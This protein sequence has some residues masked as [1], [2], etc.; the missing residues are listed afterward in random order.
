MRFHTEFSRY[1]R[2][3]EQHRLGLAY[4]R[5]LKSSLERKTAEGMALLLLNPVSV[6]RLQ[7]FITNYRWDHDGMLG[8]YQ[9]AL[10]R[11]IAGPEDEGMLNVDSS[12]FVKKGRESVGVGR[13]YCGN[14]GKVENCQS[15]VFVGYA[16]EGVYGLVDCRLYLPKG[17]LTEEYTQRG[18]KCHIPQGLEFRTKLE[19]AWELIQQVRER[20]L[21]QARW[22]GCDCTF[23]SDWAFLDEVG[24]QYWCFV[25]VRS[26]TLVWVNQPR[27]RVPRYRGRG[28]RPTKPQG[29]LSGTAMVAEIAGDPQVLWRWVK[30]AEGAKGP[31]MA[32]VARLRELRKQGQRLRR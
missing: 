11:V 22:L 10:A 3:R 18:Q 2:R 23:G 9:E 5:G 1:Y 4:L 20:G 27:M 29:V 16:G 30:L 7:D 17:W 14:L 15:S 13:Q 26:N 19:I 21:F 28:K 12:E 24:R 31:I 32:E 25:N 8:A 6:R